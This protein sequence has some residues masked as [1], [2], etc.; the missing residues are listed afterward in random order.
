MA[1]RGCR[2]GKT[3]GSVER[4]E[5]EI[6]F[7]MTKKVEGDSGDDSLRSLDHAHE[8]GE[9]CEGYVMYVFAHSK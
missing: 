2:H 9:N 3:G 8:N 5:K 7:G 6:H 1:T 4:G